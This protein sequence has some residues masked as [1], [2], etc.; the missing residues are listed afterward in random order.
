MPLHH[1]EET[2]RKLL[3]HIPTCTGRLVGDW[4]QL[5][6]DGPSL[7]RFEERVNWLRSEHNLAHGHASAIAHEF[8]LRRAARA[9]S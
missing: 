5:V 6:A 3:D 2:H 7:P 9:F 1:S 4:L 8:D